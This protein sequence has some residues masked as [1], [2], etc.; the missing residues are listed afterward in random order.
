MTAL[1]KIK[2]DLNRVLRDPLPD[3]IHIY[4]RSYHESLPVIDLDE[5]LKISIEAQETNH[6]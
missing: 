3:E 1:E 6:S 5:E 4:V 2:A